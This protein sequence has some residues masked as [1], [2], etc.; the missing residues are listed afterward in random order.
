MVRIPQQDHGASRFG[1]APYRFVQRAHEHAGRVR[2]REAQA[3]AAPQGFRRF[4]VAAQDYPRALRRVLRPTDHA[5]ALRGEFLQ[6]LRV[7]DQLPEH[8]G[9]LSVLTGFGHRLARGGD[10]LHHTIAVT[11]ELSDFTRQ[12]SPRTFLRVFV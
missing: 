7:V 1:A 5:H 3:F 9:G 10:R 12:T 8:D 4:S 2:D 6:G 11:R